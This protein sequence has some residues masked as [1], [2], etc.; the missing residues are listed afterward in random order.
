MSSALPKSL[1][2][3]FFTEANKKLE[4][5]K[6]TLG[7]YSEEQEKVIETLLTPIIEQAKTQTSFNGE[8]NENSLREAGL[9]QGG[10]SS[11]LCNLVSTFL[12]TR[13]MA[14]SQ[15]KKLAKRIEKMQ[16]E[17]EKT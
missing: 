1:L 7:Q 17:L 3:A 15:T 4:Q 16:K 11:E 6:E 8:V 9:D 2:I 10:E 5:E 12:K 13:P 14:K